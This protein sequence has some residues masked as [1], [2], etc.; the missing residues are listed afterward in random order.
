M[1]S[2]RGGKRADESCSTAG[3]GAA[4]AHWSG[5]PGAGGSN[6]PC[7]TVGSSQFNQIQRI[8]TT[9]APHSGPCSSPAERIL[10]TD[11]EVGSAPTSGSILPPVDTVTSAW[12]R[13]LVS[14]T[15]MLGFDSSWEYAQSVPSPAGH[16][17]HKGFANPTCAR[18]AVRTTAGQNVIPATRKVGRVVRQRVAN[19]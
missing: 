19:P 6:P 18:G 15:E 8:V 7:P 1:K 13:R 17:E 12:P 11:E 2:N 10:G 3:I 16:R 4:A 9:T 5:R 14:Y